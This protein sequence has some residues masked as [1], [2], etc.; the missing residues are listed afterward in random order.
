VKVCSL[1]IRKLTQGIVNALLDRL[2]DNNEEVQ[3]DALG[4]I[5]ALVVNEGQSLCKELY[6]KNIL[7][8]IEKT[9]N[10]VFFI[11][12]HSADGKAESTVRKS[13]QHNTSSPQWKFLM[14]FLEMLHTVLN[15]IWYVPYYLLSNDQ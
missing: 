9:L 5:D 13:D 11:S 14:S 7:T 8:L 6:R 1:V 15:H 3:Y 2:T 10:R 4:S 12:C